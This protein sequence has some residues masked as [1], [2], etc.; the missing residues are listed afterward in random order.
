VDYLVVFFV[1]YTIS[2]SSDESFTID[3]AEKRCKKVQ[4]IIVGMI[5]GLKNKSLVMV[6][7]NAAKLTNEHKKTYLLLF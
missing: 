4:K 2:G 6:G 1:Y 7:F 5:L 3:F